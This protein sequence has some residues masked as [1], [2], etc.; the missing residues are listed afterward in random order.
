MKI[1]C[2]FCEKY[3]RGTKSFGD[4]LIYKGKAMML[5]SHKKCL[6]K[7]IK[8]IKMLLKTIEQLKNV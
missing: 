5:P 1:R 6:D 8:H 4:V 2:I 7:E 3:I